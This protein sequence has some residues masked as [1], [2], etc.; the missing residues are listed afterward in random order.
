M[1][2]RTEKGVFHETPP[3][4]S[5]TPIN[6]AQLRQNPTIIQLSIYITKT[7]YTTQTTKPLKN[8]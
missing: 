7:S 3:D 5:N 4:R 6:V 1:D 2:K 8:V